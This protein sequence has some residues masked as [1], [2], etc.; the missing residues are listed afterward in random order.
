MPASVH[1]ARQLAWTLPAAG[2]EVE[3]LTPSLEFQ[4]PE[5]LDRESAGFFPAH[6][7]CHE[8][9]PPPRSWMQRFGANSM[10][11]RALLPM[12]RRGSELLATGRFDLVYVTTTVFNF[13]WRQLFL[14][15]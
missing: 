8:V 3:V 2:W 13:F 9:P 1:R 5:W 14:Y 7:P 10:A 15:W 4:R 6:V 11:W 12:Y